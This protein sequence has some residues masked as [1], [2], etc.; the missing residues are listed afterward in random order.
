MS[1][2]HT[3]APGDSTTR[4]VP[5]GRYGRARRPAKRWQVWVLALVAV[6][7]GSAAAYVAYLNLGAAPIEA[8]RI[9][10]DELPDNAMEITLDVRR[11]DPQR[12]GMCIVRVRALDGTESGRREVFIP[13]GETVVTAAIQ[14]VG[15][16]VTAD[17]FGCTYDVPSYLSSP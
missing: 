13:P 15:R 1:S 9:G 11:D 12:P 10:F 6:L 7:A 14:S 4:S 5:E 16:P 17:V 8:Q 3:T 2:G